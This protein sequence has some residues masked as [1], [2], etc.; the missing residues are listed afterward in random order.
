MI[1][2]PGVDVAIEAAGFRYAKTWA[3]KIER[4]LKLETDTSDILQEC[5]KCVRKWGNLSIIG[6]YVGCVCVSGGLNDVGWVI[7]MCPWAVEGG[8]GC[9]TPWVGRDV[10]DSEH[11][12]MASVG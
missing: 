5:I 2:P 7:G 9:W 12:W 11:G 6:D 4:A 10:V 8:G 1:G 3:H